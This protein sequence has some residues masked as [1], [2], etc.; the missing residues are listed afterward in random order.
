MVPYV[1][2]VDIRGLSS[3]ELIALLDAERLASHL[4]TADPEEL[5]RAQAEVAAELDRR[6]PLAARRPPEVIARLL[7]MAIGLRVVERHLGHLGRA[8]G[9]SASSAV[10]PAWA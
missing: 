6:F 10:A 3:R 1:V 4:G 7:A 9:T 5:D 2:V 8:T